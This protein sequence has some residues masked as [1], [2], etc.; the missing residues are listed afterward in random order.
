MRPCNIR[1][2]FFR[3]LPLL[4]YR[5]LTCLL[6]LDTIWLY[7]RRAALY[8]CTI[9][10]GYI[11][12]AI[13]IIAAVRSKR[14]CIEQMKLDERKYSVHHRH[15]HTPLS[16]QTNTHIFTRIECTDREPSTMRDI[17]CIFPNTDELRSASRHSFV[18]VHDWRTL[19]WMSVCVSK[20]CRT[21][22]NLAILF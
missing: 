18:Y 10:V 2:L 6:A 21:D 16:K 17:Q 11:V 1:R 12:C 7:S 22:F 4:L 3:L 20:S 9:E 5:R 8:I 13:I 14:N 19:A 15:T